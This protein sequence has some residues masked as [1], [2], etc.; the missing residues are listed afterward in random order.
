[1]TPTDQLDKKGLGGNLSKRGRDKWKDSGS[2][3]FVGMDSVP[4]RLKKTLLNLSF[5]KSE[6]S[7]ISRQ[8]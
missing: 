6:R 5:I 7:S 2:L 3:S 1:M 4:S 8:C